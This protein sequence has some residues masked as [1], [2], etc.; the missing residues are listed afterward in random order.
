MAKK[1]GEDWETKKQGQNSKN[2]RHLKE[3]VYLKCKEVS[4]AFS[5]PAGLE[6]GH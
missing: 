6:S 3:V 5:L 1:L 4:A 2:K